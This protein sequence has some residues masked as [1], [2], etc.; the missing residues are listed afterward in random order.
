MFGNRVWGRWVQWAAFV[1]IA[2]AFIIVDLLGTDK[3][4]GR[5]LFGTVVLFW[6][7]GMAFFV[8]GNRD[9]FLGRY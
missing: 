8:F 3:L 1:W 9:K 6:I 4:A 2:P 5:L 7:V